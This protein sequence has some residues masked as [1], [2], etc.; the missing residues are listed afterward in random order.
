MVARR[1]TA[2][3]FKSFGEMDRERGRPVTEDTIFRI[4]SMTKPIVS[5][6]AMMLNENGKI[7]L[8]ETL[9]KYIPEFSDM[10]VSKE[11]FEN[12]ISKESIIKPNKKNKIILT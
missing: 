8:D 5:V 3:Y 11:T 10:Y 9:D 7:Y 4:Y 1:G 2:A 6:G 12:N